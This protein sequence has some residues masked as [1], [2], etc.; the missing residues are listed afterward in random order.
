VAW[1]V[2]NEG[3]STHP[4]GQKSPNELGIYDMS[5][6]VDEWCSDWFDGYFN[7]AQ[8]NPLGPWPSDLWSDRWHI[9]RGGS[10]D[11][12]SLTIHV[13]DRG[14]KDPSL[15]TSNL[16]FRIVFSEPGSLP[17]PEMVYVEGGT[18]TMGSPASEP[19]RFDNEVPHQVTVSS[20]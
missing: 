2:D 13:T 11:G 6:N 18:F 4:V 8:T 5:G 7:V 14:C 19:G 10:Y 12:D 1:F 9:Y 3:A 17:E 15:S 20:F 16:G